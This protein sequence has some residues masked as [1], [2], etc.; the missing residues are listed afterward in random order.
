[1]LIVA[2]QGKYCGM[3]YDI[4]LAHRLRAA[5]T[6]ESGVSERPMFGGLGFLI[7]GH[8]A[9]SASGRGGI[10]VRID[11]AQAE[12]LLTLADVGRF[13]MRG[14]DLAG[15]L[16]VQPP[17]LVDDA[18]LTRWVELGVAQAR[19][20]TGSGSQTRSRSRTHPRPQSR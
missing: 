12:A 8:L 15:W 17:A 20:Q 1:M 13:Q 14:R 5:L 18:E 2:G 6:D 11:P 10:L 7:D 16:H 19:A 9:L 3:A 4:V